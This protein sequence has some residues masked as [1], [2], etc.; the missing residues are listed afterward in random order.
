MGKRGSWYSLKSKADSLDQRLQ[1][2]QG[3][4]FRQITARI[5]SINAVEGK[6][7]VTLNRLLP[8]E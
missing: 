2:L 3:K 7:T 6:S 8:N 4:S 1:N 5:K